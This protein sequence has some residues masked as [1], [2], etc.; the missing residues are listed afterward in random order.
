[1]KTDNGNSRDRVGDPAMRTL[2]DGVDVLV[3]DDSPDE[4]AMIELVLGQYGA[5]VRSAATV[6]EALDA[7]RSERPSVLVS[8]IALGLGRDGY[9]LV[10]ELRG[11]PSERGGDT[12]AVA[13]TGWCRACDATAAIDSGFQ[14]HLS[15]P[16][17]LETLVAVIANLAQ[18]RGPA[19]DAVRPEGDALTRIVWA[20]DRQ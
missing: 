8:D 19:E 7:V 11:W 6:D 17:S 13:V 14:V 12:P 9:D 2:L 1:M 5:S 18:V 20:E 15:K 4:L 10:R 3:V 16:V